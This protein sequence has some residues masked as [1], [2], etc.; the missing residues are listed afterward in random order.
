MLRTN[1]LPPEVVGDKIITFA[2]QHFTVGLLKSINKDAA[3]LW[4]YVINTANDTTLWQNSN[5][6]T[7]E[8]TASRNDK[9]VNCTIHINRTVQGEFQVNIINID[10]IEIPEYVNLSILLRKSECH[11]FHVKTEQG[12]MSDRTL[13][14]YQAIALLQYGIS[15]KDG[16]TKRLGLLG[17]ASGKGSILAMLPSCLR[18][19]VSDVG[20]FVCILPNSQLARQFRDDDVK[21]SDADLRNT[22]TIAS[23]IKDLGEWETLC[24]CTGN[25]LIIDRSE[26]GYEKKLEMALSTSTM[27]LVDEAHQIPLP[28]WAKIYDNS[29]FLFAVTGTPDEDLMTHAF[30]KAPVIVFST[31]EAINRKL[32]RPVKVKNMG[33]NVPKERLFLDAYAKYIS[34][35]GVGNDVS[36]NI[37]AIN[38]KSFIFCLN[39][40]EEAHKIAKQLND[41]AANN[42]ESDRN[43]VIQLQNGMRKSGKAQR[44]IKL[45]EE[46]QNGQKRQ[47]AATLNALAINA[48]FPIPGKNFDYYQEQIV[49]KKFSQSLADKLKQFKIYRQWAQEP[50]ADKRKGMEA[51]FSFIQT[52]RVAVSLSSH[53]VRAKIAGMLDAFAL[54]DEQKNMLAALS[55]AI[56]NNIIIAINSDTDPV[57]ALVKFEDIN[58][59]KFDALYALVVTENAAEKEKISALAQLKFGF[60][61]NVVSQGLDA[62]KLPFSTGTSDPSVL[63]LMVVGD[64]RSNTF[65][66]PTTAMQL[67]ARSVRG[68][69]GISFIVI[70][71]NTHGMNTLFDFT[72]F[73]PDNSKFVD[74]LNESFAE[75]AELRERRTSLNQTRSNFSQ[76]HKGRAATVPSVLSKEARETVPPQLVRQKTADFTKRTPPQLSRSSTSDE[77]E[78]LQIS[79][80]GKVSTTAGFFQNIRRRAITDPESKKDNGQSPKSPKL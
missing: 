45:H 63:G 61:M 25:L 35:R 74:A 68:P 24:A 19:A 53:D 79:G 2:S 65:E 1:E 47:L 62:K 42:G 43:V 56:T 54:T 55:S 9:T 67:L 76:T 10:N 39:T 72:D 34:M 80:S 22:V 75:A 40:E 38:Q 78:S 59:E 17:P 49:S 69:S 73:T 36:D 14:D 12:F 18:H 21:N 71:T 3:T 70:S 28:E 52:I 8:V 60:V 5:E 16:L 7:L 11:T 51:Q 57:D 15:L 64:T 6:F 13:R 33:N 50:D 48:I 23:E 37:Y 29:K 32:V 46:I 58:L 77:I 26:P 30:K 31:A 20:N 27:V 66:D 44:V 41:F 4:D